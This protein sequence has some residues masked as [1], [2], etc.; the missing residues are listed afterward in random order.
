MYLFLSTVQIL[1][2][3]DKKITLIEKEKSTPFK[4]SHGC[5]PFI[6]KIK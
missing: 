5:F 2:R 6:N 1:N 3:K 4:S